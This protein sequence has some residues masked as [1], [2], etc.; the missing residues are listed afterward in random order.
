[1]H[2]S[3]NILLIVA[4]QFRGDCLASSG[5][6]VV[7][8]PN[9]DELVANGVSFTR[10]YSTC[11]SCIPARRSLL[12]GLHPARHGLVSMSDGHPITQPTFPDILRR[13]GY[14]TV[15]IGRKMHQYP[16]SARYG[17]EQVMLGSTSETDDAFGND[18]SQQ[19]KGRGSIRSVGLSFNGWTARPW[20]FDEALHPT[21]WVTERSRSFLKES[22]ETCPL[23]LTAS[24]QAPHP[25]LF[26]PAFYYDRYVR[27]NLPPP[28]VGDWVHE[29]ASLPVVDANRIDLKGEA[30]RAAHAGYYGLINHLDD[31]LYWLIRDF[32]KLSSDRRREWIIIFTSDHGEMLGDHHHFRKCEPYEGSARIPLIFSASGGLGFQTGRH[33]KA[34]TCLEDLFPTLVDLAGLELKDEVDGKSL[35]PV[36]LGQREKVR[37]LL[38]G[39]HGKQY[40]SEQAHHFLTDEKWK[41]IWRSM[42]GEEQ[43]FDLENDPRETRN[44][45]KACPTI[46]TRFREEL[47]ELLKGR[48]EGFVHDGK[49]HPVQ[50]SRA[51][52]LGK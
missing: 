39:E 18:L 2:L 19:T 7:M 52:L 36:L 4:D 25:P 45:S 22:D 34:L 50:Q 27:M 37:T 16:A 12:T 31:Q 1:M 17:F 33:S 35:L 8:T 41:Y 48:P 10:A 11:P 13:S 5:H 14:Q 24:Y 38:H 43:L 47:I 51:F 42:T 40:S 21:T 9:L 6:P 29:P 26:P 32:K 46:L 20:P 30:L 23:F 28:A 44:Q 49:L 15:M 3:P